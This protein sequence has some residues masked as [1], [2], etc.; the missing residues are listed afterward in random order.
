[1]S[2]QSKRETLRHLVPHWFFDPVRPTGPKERQ[3]HFLGSSI[4]AAVSVKEAHLR[5]EAKAAEFIE[6]RESINRQ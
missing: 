1:M 4:E 5:A 3:V 6:R 2:F